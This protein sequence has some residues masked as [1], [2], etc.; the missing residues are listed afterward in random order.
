MINFAVINFKTIVKNII[1]AI[2]LIILIIGIMNIGDLITSSTKKFS[3]VDI[4]KNNINI[5]FNTDENENTFAKMLSTEIPILSSSNSEAKEITEKKVP[6]NKTIETSSKS[7]NNKKADKP[8][9][10]S[11]KEEVPKTV[12]T[13]VI[14]ENNLP[15]SY[16]ATYNTVKIKNETSINLSQEILTPNVDYK[17]KKNI[18]IFHTHTCES[19]TPTEKNPYAASGN[20]RT[21]D[22][23]HSVAQV[24]KCFTRSLNCKRI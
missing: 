12:A 14:S 15:E 21:I 3:Y 11:N 6:N 13:S 23:N 24:R 22:L 10:N 4:V 9:D 20:F 1:K 17:D 2:I 7:S 19:Y 8:K 18:I 5:Q 16:N